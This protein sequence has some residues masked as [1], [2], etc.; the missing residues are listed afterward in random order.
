MGAIQNLDID[1]W[2]KVACF[3]PQRERNNL[4][5]YL[6]STCL[7][8]IYNTE[9]LTQ[10]MFMQP[11]FVEAEKEDLRLS[12]HVHVITTLSTTVCSSLSYLM[13]MGFSKNDAE[14][15]LRTSA[16]SV[17]DAIDILLET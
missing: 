10:Y 2:G 5:L 13:A 9:A 16:G 4:F 6:R 3:L 17:S 14:H 7:I 8:P 11:S 15:A 1:L 12:E